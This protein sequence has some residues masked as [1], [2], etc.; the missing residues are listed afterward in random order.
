MS[1]REL[2]MIE[3]KEVL[4]RWSAQ[5]SLHQIA[6]ETGLDRKTVRRYVQAAES[7]GLERDKELDDARVH[8]VAER[9]QARVLPARTSEWTEIAEHRGRIEEWL[10]KR[11]PLRLRKIHTLLVRD[12]GLKA[13]YDTLRRFAIEELGWSKRPPTVRVDDPPPGQEAQVDFGYLS[14]IVDSETGKKKRLYV[15][16]VTLSFSRYQFVWPTFSQTT[17]A[18][19]DGL[20]AAWRFF[21]GVTKT[22]VPDNMSSVV[23]R[24]DSLS[25]TLVDAF[26]DYV[27]ARGVFV[28]PARVRSPQDKPRVENQVAF[29]RE[30][31]FDGEHFTGLDDA[32]RSAENWCRDI[33]GR[34]VHGTTRQV[35]VEV[36]EAFEKPALLPAPTA[37]FDVPVWTDAKVHPDLHI[38]VARA[39]YS[40]PTCYL[41]KRVRARA[42]KKTV[43][44]YFRTELIKMHPRQPPGGRS[45]D[46]HD[47][48]VGKAAYALR[49]VDGLL[50]SAK[51]KGPHVGLF[52]ERILAGP[53]PWA[54]MRQGYALLRLC[55]K[56]GT[57]H[58]EAVCQSALAFDVVDVVRITRMLKSAIRPKL[59][60]DTPGK[61]V[62]ITSAPR[63]AR[64]VE[65]FATRSNK[66]GD[67]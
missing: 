14:E 19:C 28:D 47:Y 24:A 55:D 29:V 54:R 66:E 23:V 53:L 45:T 17:E 62:S 43:K 38:Q 6:R 52:A 11:R 4:R 46:P 5:Q 49:S 61:L 65:H 42:D 35:P 50:A 1:Y 22:I 9:V 10:G 20:D 30:S 48:P 25:P 3:I 21:G 15:L 56:Y 59:T 67:R 13:S 32:R 33:A 37:P 39:L 36:F 31:W 60:D 2:T 41:R 51:E 44:I 12:C 8:A 57:G 27:Q 34:R 16:I 18:V 26:V 58:V 7:L 64:S 63:F 40:V